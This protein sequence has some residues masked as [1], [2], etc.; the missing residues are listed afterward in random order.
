[1]KHAVVSGQ[2]SIMGSS[3]NQRSGM[4]Q[5]LNMSHQGGVESM[6]RAFLF[7]THLGFC[8]PQS[9]FGKKSGL[10]LTGF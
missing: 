6:V 7:R 3:S 5:H 1:M 8:R 10:S 4:A 2:T 9:L